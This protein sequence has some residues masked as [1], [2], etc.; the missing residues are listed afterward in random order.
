MN[1]R[2]IMKALIGIPLLGLVAKLPEAKDDQ[3]REV[4]VETT[5]WDSPPTQSVVFDPPVNGGAFIDLYR[6]VGPYIVFDEN[7]IRMYD[8][9]DIILWQV[10]SDG[11]VA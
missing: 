3:W 5:Y 4:L 11:T 2:E 7:G 8:S 9:D 10:T 6:E 1:R